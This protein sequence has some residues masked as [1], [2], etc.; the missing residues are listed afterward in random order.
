[1]A[2]TI[3]DIAREFGV[4]PSTVSNALNGRYK[5]AYRKT[6]ARSEEI[7]AYAEEHGYRPNGAAR[8]IRAQRTFLIGAVLPSQPERPFD[9]PDD[10][11]SDVGRQGFVWGTSGELG[12]CRILTKKV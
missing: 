1:M 8:A 5:G 10:I 3:K 12:G 4:A 7:R 2:I 11:G 9:H 6:A